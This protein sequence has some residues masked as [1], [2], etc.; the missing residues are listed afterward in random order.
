ME[1]MNTEAPHDNVVI[2]V[3]NGKGRD[4]SP[5]KV[6]LC[7]GDLASPGYYGTVNVDKENLARFTELIETPMEVRSKP[8]ILHT[9]AAKLIGSSASEKVRTLNKDWTRQI[10]PR[11]I[12]RSIFPKDFDHE[13]YKEDL[14]AYRK[15]HPKISRRPSHL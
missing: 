4:I 8:G 1:R 7:A 15:K 9:L 12:A 10:I 5:K 11:A 13:K 14:E 6:I 3:V 2:R